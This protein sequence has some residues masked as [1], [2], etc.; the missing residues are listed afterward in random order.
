MKNFKINSKII[1]AMLFFAALSQKVL[2]QFTAASLTEWNVGNTISARNTGNDIM[3]IG[4][5]TFR[6][7]VYDD[8]NNTNPGLT[9]RVNYG[10]T[11]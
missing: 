4:S 5:N 6:V 1:F 8:N 3:D 10:G 7:N 11:L 2:A 9:Y